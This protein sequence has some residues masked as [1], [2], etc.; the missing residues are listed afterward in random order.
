[1]NEMR[2]MHMHMHVCTYVY[3]ALAGRDERDEREPPATYGLQPGPAVR[4]HEGDEHPLEAVDLVG[5]GVGVGVASS[6]GR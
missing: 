5:V 2:C 6:R 3:L 1:M 4:L